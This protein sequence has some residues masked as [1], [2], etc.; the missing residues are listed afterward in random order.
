MSYDIAAARDEVATAGWVV[1]QICSKHIKQYLNFLFPVIYWSCIKIVHQDELER[2]Q[3]VQR[4]HL[5]SI[6]NNILS[7]ALLY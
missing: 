3:H 6:K 7:D 4:W 5:C 2:R 1:S